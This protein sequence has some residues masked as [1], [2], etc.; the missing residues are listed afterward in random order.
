MSARTAGARRHPL[1]IFFQ[2]HL[3]RRMWQDQLAQVTFMR[4]APAAF[5][6]VTIPMTQQEPF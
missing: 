5:A 1:E 2:D 6:L 3:H 4:C